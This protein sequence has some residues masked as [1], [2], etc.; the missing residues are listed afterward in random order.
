MIPY[1]V[2]LKYSWPAL[3]GSVVTSST[4]FMFQLTTPC[5]AWIQIL[6]TFGQFRACWKVIQVKFRMHLVTCLNIKQ[7]LKT[8]HECVEVVNLLGVQR[9]VA[10]LHVLVGVPVKLGHL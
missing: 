2:S 9:V 4:M 6:V 1:L 7:D 3:L 8:E 5:T 10:H